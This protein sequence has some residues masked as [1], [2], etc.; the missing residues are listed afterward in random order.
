MVIVPSEISIV[1]KSKSRALEK[2]RTLL[3]IDR[4]L[5]ARATRLHI[6]IRAA[7]DGDLLAQGQG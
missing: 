6:D 2:R 7:Q 1:A 3:L 4:D 5:G